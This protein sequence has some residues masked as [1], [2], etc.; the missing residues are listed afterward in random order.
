[1][2]WLIEVN[3][4]TRAFFCYRNL[5]FFKNSWKFGHKRFLTGHFFE[6]TVQDAVQLLTKKFGHQ[7]WKCIYLNAS[8]K[9]KI[10]LK[11]VLKENCRVHPRCDKIFEKSQLTSS[12]LVTKGAFFPASGVISR[13][14]L[15]G[16]KFL[17]AYLTKKSSGVLLDIFY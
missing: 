12:D 15:N 11:F 4:N 8:I 1:M 3:S 13:A 16:W 2:A 10:K 7:N 17:F 14:L 9:F 6:Q 5:V